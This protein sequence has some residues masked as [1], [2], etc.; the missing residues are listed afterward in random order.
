MLYR[1]LKLVP[2]RLP[3]M[4]GAWQPPEQFEAAVRF[5]PVAA[6]VRAA[7]AAG[8]YTGPLAGKLVAEAVCSAAMRRLLSTG[9]RCSGWCGR[10]GAGCAA[11]ARQR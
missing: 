1:T 2:L 3:L 9:S 11:R 8:T 6:A 4:Q 7:L 5:A 10:L